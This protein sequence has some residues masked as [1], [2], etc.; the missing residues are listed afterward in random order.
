M[1]VHSS[2]LNPIVA[3]IIGGAGLLSACGG[4]GNS[5]DTTP[6]APTTVDLKTAVIDGPIRNALV[7]LDKNDDG[8]CDAG[9]PSARTAADGSA[10]LQVDPADIGK[11]TVLALVGTDAVDGAYGPV[12]VPFALRAPADHASVVSPL[13]TLVR[14]QMDASGSSSTEAAQAVQDVAGISAPLFADYNQGTD[15]GAK[16]AASL[17]RF[18]VLAKQEAAGVLAA[19]VGTRDSSGATI[20]GA[21]LE[22]AVELRLIDLIPSI[23]NA[24]ATDPNATPA[25]L[26]S[27]AQTVLAAELMLTAANV[28]SVVGLAKQ[29][30]TT[31]AAA[32]PTAGASMEWFRYTDGDNW[33]FPVFES[34][35]AQNAPDASGKTHFTDKRKQAVGGVVTVWGADAAFTNTAAYFDGTQWFVCPTDFV[36]ASTPRDAAGRSESFYCG[37]FHSKSQRSMRDISGL[38]MADIVSDIRAY[39]LPSTAGAFTQWGPDPATGVLGNAVFPA[40]SK[41]FYQTTT[42]IANPDAYNAVATNTVGAYGAEI[43]AGGTPVY[44]ANGVTA[45]ACGQVTTANAASLFHDIQTLDDLVARYPGKPCIFGASASAGPRNDWWGQSTISIGD[46]SGPAPANPYYRSTRTVRAGFGAGNSLTY[47][48]CARRASDG[49]P[50]NCDPIGTGTYAIETVGDARVMRLAGVPAAAAQLNYNRI[51]V[52]RGGKVYFGFRTKLTVNHSV[53]PNA[54]ATDA[55]FTQL[56]QPGLSR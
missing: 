31:P 17:A 4:G 36:H 44:D 15:D 2:K 43:A 51:F 25:A 27:S 1:K 33:Y 41:L 23:V 21:D 16:A 45:T 6:A 13:T 24:G 12:T 37:A 50:R 56:A 11:F 26:L 29:V 7:C 32:T 18:L 55:L 53:R 49:S 22:R 3:A 30:D 47:Y 14:A 5:V 39:P 9:E 48:D 34:T 52:E 20:T 40:G 35:A 19:A 42:P 54:E 8:A 10:T 38:K 28:G 46:V